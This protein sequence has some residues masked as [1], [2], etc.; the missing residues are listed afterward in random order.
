MGTAFCFVSRLRSRIVGYRMLWK[1]TLLLVTSDLL[2][3]DS[4]F[5]G[6]VGKAHN[7]TNKRHIPGQNLEP[8]S[9]QMLPASRLLFHY[10]ALIIVL[11]VFFLLSLRFTTSIRSRYPNHQHPT[12]PLWSIDTTFRMQFPT[13]SV[14]LSQQMILPSKARTSFFAG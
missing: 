4:D 8:L 13:Q 6:V 2:L 14:I 7:S 12:P 3:R 10:L 11:L 1:H 5:G 9:K